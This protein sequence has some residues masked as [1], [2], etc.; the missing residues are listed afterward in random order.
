MGS[1]VVRLVALAVVGASTVAPSGARAAEVPS[2]AEPA[3][4]R[5]PTLDDREIEQ[6]LRFRI[7]RQ[8]RAHSAVVG[9]LRPGGRSIVAY[10]GRDAPHAIE[11]RGD[12]IFEIASLTKVFTALLLADAVTR[13]EVRLD[14]PLSRYVPPGVTVPGSPGRAITLVDLA[15]HTSGLPLRPDNLN[16][17]PD[18]PNKYAGYTLE[19]LHA[20]LPE[21]RLAHAPGTTF[22][23]SNLAYALLGHAL[24]RHARE[25]FPDLLR[26]RITAPLGLADTRFDDDP[27]TAARRARG[28]DTDLKPVGATSNGALSPAGGLRSTASDLLQLLELFLRREGPGDLPRAAQSMLTVDRPGDGGDTRMALGWRRTV[29][30]GETYYWSHGSSDGSRTFMGFNP[31]RGV[32]VVALADAASGGGLDD[33]GWRVLDPLEPV[34]L[35]V[36]P[37]RTAIELPAAAIQRVLGTYRHAPDDE[38]TV[39]RGA[40]GL[41]VTTGP[42]QFLVQPESRT[43][44]FAKGGGDLTLEF[45]GPASKPPDRMVLRENGKR[46]VYRRVDASAAVSDRAHGRN[47]HDPR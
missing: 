30:H 10:R 26:R 20:G 25:P 44:F 31:A 18:A 23:Y 17:A 27:G 19:Q 37:R 40:T 29:A 11:P 6:L 28:H 1:K 16:A 4:Q 47:P 41:I 8:R 3:P 22:Q 13:G 32:A 39:T 45:P 35:K 33:I 5:V 7:D 38:M 15:T 24:A 43:R 46:F 9:V 2:P 34:D 14:D 12:T 21:Y 42:G 36:V